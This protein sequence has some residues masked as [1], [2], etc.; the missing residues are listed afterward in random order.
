MRTLDMDPKTED[1]LIRI[2]EIIR[3]NEQIIGCLQSEINLKNP[4]V[5]VHT[6]AATALKTTAEQL[7]ALDPNADLETVPAPVP[8]A[9][10]TKGFR[11]RKSLFEEP[12]GITRE[13]IRWLRD[14]WP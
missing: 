5:I 1:A 2:K 13:S 11:K 12:R 3:M 8:S 9:L 7:K 10:S 14:W 6:R 4:S